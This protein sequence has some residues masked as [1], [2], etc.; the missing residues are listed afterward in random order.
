[1]ILVTIFWL[2]SIFT[3]LVGFIYFASVGMHICSV[4]S[5]ALMSFFIGGYAGTISSLVIKSKEYTFEESV[6]MYQESYL[7]FFA[8]IGGLTKKLVMH[9]INFVGGKRDVKKDNRDN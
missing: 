9:V 1:M 5:I 2:L 8:E 3:P 7:G 6:K 4:A